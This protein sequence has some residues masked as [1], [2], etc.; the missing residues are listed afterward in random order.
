MNAKPFKRFTIKSKHWGV[1][2]V[3]VD[4]EDAY[5]LRSYVWTCSGTKTPSV[6][7]NDNGIAIPLSHVLMDSKDPQWVSHL[8]GCQLDFRKSNLA[9]RDRKAA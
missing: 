2:V 9:V 4:V 1:V 7:R 3:T 8:N 6:L 5:L